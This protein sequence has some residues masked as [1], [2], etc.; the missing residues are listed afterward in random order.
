MVARLRMMLQQHHNRYSV[1]VSSSQANLLQTQHCDE[2]FHSI[3]L[4]LIAHPLKSAIVRNWI[5]HHVMVAI[6]V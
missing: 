1:C 4:P 5:S 6:F 3:D 2:I